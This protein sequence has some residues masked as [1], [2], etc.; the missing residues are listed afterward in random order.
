MGW[1]GKIL[2]APLVSG[3]C[4]GQGHVPL[5][6]ETSPSLCEV[7]EGGAAGVVLLPASPDLL[8]GLCE[9]EALLHVV[10]GGR[11][12]VNIADARE[13][14]L[15]PAVLLQGLRG[16]QQPQ[17]PQQCGVTP[18]SPPAARQASSQTQIQVSCSSLRSVGVTPEPGNQAGSH[19]R[20]KGEQQPPELAE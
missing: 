9:E 18:P 6:E 17:Q 2:K 7:H 4:P 3:P 20:A 16:E 5:E 10:V 8:E 11:G 1:V 19:G 12:A 14:R 15:H 13:A